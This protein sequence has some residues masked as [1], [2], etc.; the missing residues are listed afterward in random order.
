MK[1]LTLAAIAFIKTTA[2]TI[3]MSDYIC[4]PYKVNLE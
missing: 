4:E 3:Y 1:R 2:H